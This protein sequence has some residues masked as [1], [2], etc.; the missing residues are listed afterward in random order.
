MAGVIVLNVVTVLTT[1]T[2]DDRPLMPLGWA[3][4]IASS[5]ALL[6]RHRFPVAVL[7][8]TAATTLTYYPLGFPDAPIVL[9]LVIALYT[10]ARVRGVLL[11]VVTAG[12][13]AVA[14][15]AAAEEPFQVAIGVVPVLLLPV[16]LGE[17]ARIRARQTAQAEERARLAEVN[18]ES[19]ALRRAAEERLRIARELHDVLAHQVSLIN[20]QAGAALH[21]REPDSAF[22]ALRTIRTASGDALREIRSVLGMLRDP[23]QPDLAALPELFTHAETAGL[24]LRVKVD[25]PPPAL[26][27]AVQLTAYRIVQEALTNVVRH[28]SAAAADI[29]LHRTGTSV[30]VS[31]ED[32]GGTV[33]GIQDGNGIRGMAERVAAIGGEFRAE[34]RPGGGFRV[35]AR[36]P[37]ALDGNGTP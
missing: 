5:A 27:P 25:L 30:E 6:A 29:D 23:M 7:I 16:V 22:E 21:T 3:L 8:V 32:S 33:Q 9:N 1:T 17:L 36:L 34:P 18:L 11:S 4:L 13:L 2:G 10:V 15:S 24:T 28:S 26:P 19:E 12:L 35:H 31:V 20:V 14:A 37:V